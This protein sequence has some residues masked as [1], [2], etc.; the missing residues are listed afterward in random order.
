MQNIKLLCGFKAIKVE[1][2]FFT[3]N[4][5]KQAENGLDTHIMNVEELGGEIT[6]ECMPSMRF[7]DGTYKL[8]LRVK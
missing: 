4:A 5:S 7:H 8:K 3:K 6:A 2:G 1:D